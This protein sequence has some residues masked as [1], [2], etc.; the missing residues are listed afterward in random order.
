MMPQPPVRDLSMCVCVSV[1]LCIC[2]SVC[3][4]PCLALTSRVAASR[5]RSRRR[6][7]SRQPV[8][9]CLSVSLSLRLFVRLLRGR[10]LPASHRNHC[11]RD[12]LT[13]TTAR[14]SRG[15]GERA[16]AVPRLSHAGWLSDCAPVLEVP[17]P[18]CISVTT[19]LMCLRVSVCLCVHYIISVSL[20]VSV[21]DAPILHGAGTG[22]QRLAARAVSPTPRALPLGSTTHSYPSTRRTTQ[23][24]SH[25]RMR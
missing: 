22:A 9:P 1:C 8:S 23:F 21:T 20:C 18:Y 7:R 10:S 12:P 14:E 2:A 3:L 4:S 13:A 24:P 6:P 11:A 25:R 16:A 5:C 17:T 19:L 15:R